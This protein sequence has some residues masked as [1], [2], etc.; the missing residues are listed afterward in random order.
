[1]NRALR[2]V[3]ITALMACCALAGLYAGRWFFDTPAPA[4]PVPVSTPAAESLVEQLPDFTLTDLDGAAR[5][6]SEWA[7]RPML[8]NFWATWCA[9]C[10][11]EMPLLQTLHEDSPGGLRVIG[12]AVDRAPAVES[13][14]AE[15][16]VTY[17]ILVG[18][19]DAIAA[20][21]SFGPEFIALPFSVLV[22]SDGAV[23]GL[24]AGEL[25]VAELR[26]LARLAAE[27]SGGAL[28]LAEAREA[29]PGS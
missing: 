15:A 29:F 27:L 28:T 17:P 21:E 2:A 14:I 8:I 19:E 9:P 26:G 12:I 20:A 22:D 25:D 16:G 6:I 7:D 24:E 10:R 3:R 1:M 23:V 11:K 5:Q 4:A 13:F 18:Q